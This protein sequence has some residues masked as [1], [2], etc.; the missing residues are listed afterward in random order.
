MSASR[1][2]FAL[3]VVLALSAAPALAAQ[4]TAPSIAAS[5][6]TPGLTIT[7]AAL[8]AGKLSIA[9]TASNIGV[10]VRINGTSFT[11]TANAE[12]KFSFNV[13]YRT[14]DCR[15]IL[16]TSTGWLQFMIGNCGPGTIA[17]GPWAATKL[18]NPGDLV[19]YQGATYRSVNISR[20]QVPATALT[21]WQPY[22]AR[23]LP[24]PQ[25][26]R[27]YAG[28]PG[29]TGPAGPA[30]MA[31]APGPMGPAGANGA[32]G[33]AGPQGPTG[34]VTR[35]VFRGDPGW[36][37][38]SSSYW[39]FIG[40]TVEVTVAAGQKLTGAATVPLGCAPSC[41]GGVS[42]SVNFWHDLCYQLMPA[43]APLAF[44]GPDFQ[45]SELST[46]RIP[47]SVVGSAAPPTAGVYRVG[48][49]VWLPTGVAITD[50]D[51]M[52]GWVMVHN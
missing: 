17:Q 52:T 25:G 20:N 38:D 9:G 45:D 46:T 41:G 21:Y 33:P 1:C 27:G 34:I 14:S 10:V 39:I 32:P 30:G 6:G 13:A 7:Q 43:G 50:T 15:I 2:L 4:Q 35:A 36:R 19:T 44:N 5:G 26:P 16:A 22:A 28:L 3:S 12:R 37:I 49:C 18:Y 47:Y 40:P 24:G 31:G 51:R 42:G 8:L 11:A 48:Y 23:G 29:P